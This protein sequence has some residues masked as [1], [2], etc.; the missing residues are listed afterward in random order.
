M[1]SEGG[2]MIASLIVTGICF[3]IFI[4]AVIA[5]FAKMENNALAVIIGFLTIVGS[6]IFTYLL[7]KM[8]II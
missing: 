3:I 1:R 6:F 8:G 4:I 2:S 5:E 7:G